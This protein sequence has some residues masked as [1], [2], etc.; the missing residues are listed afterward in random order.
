MLSIY[1][2]VFLFFKQKT[3]YEMRISDWSSDVCSSDL[4]GCGRGGAGKHLIAPLQ[5]IRH[6][7]GRPAAKSGEDEHDGRA[8]GD[9][10]DKPARTKPLHRPG[11]RKRTGRRAQRVD[12]DQPARRAD[13]PGGAAMAVCV[14]EAERIKGKATANESGGGK[15]W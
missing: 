3:A 2:F 6:G 12:Q 9:E 10:E 7:R 13:P 14:R 8:T 15:E 5:R 4:R 1:L 11:C